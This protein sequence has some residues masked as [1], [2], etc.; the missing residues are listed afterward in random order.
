[1]SKFSVFATVLACSLTLSAVSCMGPNYHP[2]AAAGTPILASAAVPGAGA[3]SLATSSPWNGSGIFAVGI[4]MGLVCIGTS[5][6]IFRAK[7]D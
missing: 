7:P 6:Y 4:I 1:M 5:M 3:T 2:P